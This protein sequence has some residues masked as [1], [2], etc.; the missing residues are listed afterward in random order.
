[1]ISP[2][3][4]PTAVN[5]SSAPP[6]LSQ[7]NII[8][9]A[10]LTTP[11]GGAGAASYGNDGR[12]DLGPHDVRSATV[13][14]VKR[15]ILACSPALSLD[16]GGSS[17][18]RLWWNGFLLDDGGS[19]VEEA[20]RRWKVPESGGGGEGTALQFFLTMYREKRQRTRSGSFQSLT[21]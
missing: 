21:W 9:I 18:M 17:S 16:R 20:M 15:R 1:M 10:P 4:H 12:L 2:V 6:S 19:T 5:N 3:A 11:I 13:E 14:D 7:R 8:I